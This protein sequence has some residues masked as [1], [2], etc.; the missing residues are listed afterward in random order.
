MNRLESGDKVKVKSIDWFD[1][2]C[3]KD[4]HLNKFSNEIERSYSIGP[5]RP[6][7]WGGMLD[8][9]EKIVTISR[10]LDKSDGMYRIKEDN[11][12]YIWGDYMFDVYPFLDYESRIKDFCNNQCIYKCKMDSCK[13]FSQRVNYNNL[14]N[15]TLK[16]SEGDEVEIKSLEWFSMYSIRGVCSISVDGSTNNIVWIPKLSIKNLFGKK[17][18]ITK[19]TKDSNNNNLYSLKGSNSLWPIIS[20]DI[21]NFS[22]DFSRRVN[23]FCK[24]CI[25]RGDFCNICS[26]NKNV[27]D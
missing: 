20:F 27:K 21:D 23:E 16:L 2:Y 14:Y 7:F 10:Q 1:K 3:S 12:K 26:L 8:Y 17:T 4:Y 5:D 25:L 6:Y 15:S 13:L 18:V 9:S 22:V 19:I 24:D 11:G